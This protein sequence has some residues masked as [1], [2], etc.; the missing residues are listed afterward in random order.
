MKKR[1][2]LSR[3]KTPWDRSNN[4]T[5]LES[6]IKENYQNNYYK[7]HIKIRDSCETDIIN[8]IKVDN[9]KICNS[10]NIIKFGKTKE[11][12]QRYYCKDCHKKFIP[13]KNTIFENHKIPI[14]EWI[15]FCLNIIDYGSITITS[16]NNK[17]AIT[18]SRYWLQKLF[19]IL[20]DYQK[21]IILKDKVYLDETYYSVIY[22]D[23]IKSYNGK[24]TSAYIN[25]YC[26]GIACDNQNVIAF[27]E[28]KSKTSSNKT[29]KFFINKIKQKSILVHDKENS[30][31]ILVRE[32]N[33]K[34]KSYNSEELKKLSDKDNP[35]YKINHHCY[36]LKK[37]LNYHSGFDRQYLQD[38]L[39]LY[40]FINNKPN[41]KLEKVE[42]ILNKAFNTKT[43]LKYRDF[44][45]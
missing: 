28:G 18:T 23:R 31:N 24:I 5:Q 15:E 8:S 11:G 39:N 36:L 41:N 20:K 29:K 44:F 21:D 34:N 10:L 27:V 25:K 4:L 9:C 19:L 2:N 26:I 13:T 1:S 17:N 40:C 42:Y 22:R 35:L 43:T 32:L 45:D 38:Y 30:H 3:R 12:I 6:F 14:K 7:K 16:K 37:F 33:L